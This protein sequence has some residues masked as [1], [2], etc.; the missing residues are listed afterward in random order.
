MTYVLHYA[1]DNASVIVR[2]ALEEMGLPYRAVLVDRATRAQQG[3]DFR[4][5]NPAGLIPALETPRGVMFETAAILLWLADTHG[6]M[7]PAA[8]SAARPAFLSALVFTSNTLHAQ[9]R[10]MFY[11]WKYVGPDQ[12]AQDSLRSK[13]LDTTTPDM[14]L[15]MGLHLLDRY[16]ANRDPAPNARPW[17]LDYYIAAILRWC[18]IYPAGWTGWCDL[19]A[20]PALDQLT[21]M[22][23]TRPAVGRV[24]QAE[25]L[26]PRPFTD[27][28]LP[29][30]PEGSAL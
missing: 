24:A 13:L 23:E 2:L 6:D 25:G 21:K 16:Y 10:M 1:P 30:P 9:L 22:L 14:S 4:A 12:D 29:T 17:V 5:L 8:D 26:G 28:H 20:Y 7:A 15:P 11:P 27:P 3:P 18:R 19:A